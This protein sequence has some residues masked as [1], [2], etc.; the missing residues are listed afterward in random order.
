MNTSV[1][2][3]VTR[4]PENTSRARE[5]QW[6]MEHYKNELARAG[7]QKEYAWRVYDKAIEDPNIS[8]EEKEE[9][10]M[11]AE[12]LDAIADEAWRDYEKAKADY[13]QLFN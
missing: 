12:I 6:C 1:T 11:M 8:R 10:A 7:S 2:T 13:L 9:I 3:Y 4:L 5:L